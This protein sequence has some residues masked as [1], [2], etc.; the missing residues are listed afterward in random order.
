M[1]RS[2]KGASWLGRRHC[3]PD[4]RALVVSQAQGLG[5]NGGKLV[6]LGRILRSLFGNNNKEQKED[7]EVYVLEFDLCSYALISELIALHD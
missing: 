7:P 2:N 4:Q 3:A 6:P 1:P 5:T